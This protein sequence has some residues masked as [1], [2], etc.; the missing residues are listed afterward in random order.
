MVVVTVVVAVVVVV[1]VV[2]VVAVVV[3]VSIIFFVVVVVVTIG[4]I[5]PPPKLYSRP[6]GPSFMFL[7][8]EFQTAV[9]PDHVKVQKR[10][11]HPLRLVLAVKLALF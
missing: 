6:Q 1:V 5:I 2:V 10:P 3:L 9:Q 4:N 7:P 8:F 11:A